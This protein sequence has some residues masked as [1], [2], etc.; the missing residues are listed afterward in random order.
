[1]PGISLEKV[2]GMAFEKLGIQDKKKLL[3]ILAEMQKSGFLEVHKN[4]NDKRAYIVPVWLRNDILKIKPTRIESDMIGN[5][6]RSCGEL[7]ET[8]NDISECYIL[9]DNATECLTT[10]SKGKELT[11][12]EIVN[13]DNRIANLLI[14]FFDRG[15][16]KYNPEAKKFLITP[17]GI[18][19]TKV[20]INILKISSASDLWSEFVRGTPNLDSMENDF[21][22]VSNEIHS[23][24]SDKYSAKD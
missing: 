13:I 20:I 11:L 17:E 7:W 18:D 8:I 2:E 23:T 19:S 6:I 9:I 14:S 21:G 1:M 4:N 3:N 15:L 10:L 22:D 5:A 12:R 24:I 16:L